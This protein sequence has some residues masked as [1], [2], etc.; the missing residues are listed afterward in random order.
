MSSVREIFVHSRLLDTSQLIRL[1]VPFLMVFFLFD[2]EY[3]VATILGEGERL[4]HSMI[5][6]DGALTPIGQVNVPIKMSDIFTLLIIAVLLIR[7][8]VDRAPSIVEP[9]DLS[10]YGFLVLFAG[11]GLVALLLNASSYSTA[12]FSV[13]LLY[14][15]KFLEVSLIYVFVLV[16][17]RYGGGVPVLLRPVVIAGFVAALLGLFYSFGGS[18]VGWLIQDRVQFF[19]TLALLTM[20]SLSIVLSP[21][22]VQP[23]IGLSR[24]NLWLISALMTISIYSCGKRTVIIGFIAGLTYLHI[25]YLSRRIWRKIVVSYLVFLGMGSPFLLKQVTRSFNSE[26]EHIWDGLETKYADRLMESPIAQVNIPGLDYSITARIGRWFVSFDR[27]LEHPF[28][29]IGFFGSPYVYDFLPDSA[30][31]QILI[32]TGIIGF[33]LLGAFMVRSWLF[34]NK[35]AGGMPCSRELGIGFQG[36]FVVIMIMGLS[37]NSIYIFSLLGMFLAFAALSRHAS[38]PLPKRP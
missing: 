33:L 27:I 37:A 31:F 10:Q 35:T 26:G 38:R 2:L 14:L 23:V 21:N 5:L 20:I 16:F 11:I 32:E 24:I 6:I 12:Q 8:R 22:P 3:N 1:L 34:S 15:A 9:V 17:F 28:L 36:A 30:F 13:S 4:R 29:G 19:G 7:I 25:K 18:S